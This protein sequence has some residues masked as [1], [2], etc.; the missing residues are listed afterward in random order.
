KK[1]NRIQSG[2]VVGCIGISA[3]RSPFTVEG[4]PRM[5]GRQGPFRGLFERGCRLDGRGRQGKTAAG[6]Y[7]CLI[8]P[9]NN[10]GLA[11]AAAPSRLTRDKVHR[12]VAR[13]LGLR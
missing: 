1:L 5:P 7:A 10:D 9:S 6:V 11:A 12:D 8:A 13:H 4:E 2:L 3:K